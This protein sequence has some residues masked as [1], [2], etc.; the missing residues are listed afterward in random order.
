ML[1]FCVTINVIIMSFEGVFGFKSIPTFVV[2]EN[3]KI[4]AIR[5]H[6]ASQELNPMVENMAV[7]KTIAMHSQTKALEKEGIKVYSL[8]VG[9]PDYDPPFEVIQATGEAAANGH[10]KYTSVNGDAD[11]REAI[12]K[13]LYQRKNTK[14]TPEQ[15]VVSNGAK[16]AVFQGLLAVVKPGD[17]VIVPAPYWPSYPDMVKM[18]YAT[19]VILDTFPENGYNIDPQALRTLLTSNPKISCIILC[20]PSNPTGGVSD[21][22]TLEAMAAVFR[23]F[24]KV[25]IISDE[26]YERLTYGIQHV[27]F[28]ALPDM[29]D[30]TIVINGFSKS[31]SMTGYRIGYSASP[32][33]IA[34][35]CSKIQSQMTS[36]ASSV[37]QKA[38]LKALQDVPS[39]WIDERLLELQSKRDLAYDLVTN[40][41]NVKCPKPDGAFYLLPDVSAYY[42][43]KTVATEKFPSV[44]I[45]DSDVLCLELLRREQVALVAG[46]GFGAGN[47][48]R[49]SYAASIDMITESLMRLKRFLVSLE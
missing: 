25:R 27:S 16:Q 48:I 36:C 46:D 42:N 37:G 7:S 26:I 18:C 35:A 47:C 34:K 23:D 11:L 2:N 8:C 41:P 22:P 17:E 9:E 32:L 13:D 5:L 20:N 28:S 44:I 15:I 19:P 31:H 21:G 12:A 45:T 24:P 3:V 33:Y 4:D 6:S 14:Y 49:I 30:R 10:T 39:S 38:A 40:I 1:K 43:K 29:M